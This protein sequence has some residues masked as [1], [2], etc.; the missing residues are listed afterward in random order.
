[1]AT[2]KIIDDS[3]REKLNAPDHESLDIDIFLA[4]EPAQEL[5]SMTADPTADA[6]PMTA[7]AVVDTLTS[8]A[9]ASQEGVVSMLAQNAMD[10]ALTDDSVTQPSAV[11]LKQYWATNSV[12]ARVSPSVLAQ[13]LERE[14]VIAI[15]QARYAPLEELMDE[16]ALAPVEDAPTPLAWSVTKINAPLLWARGIDGG[17]IVVAVVDTGVNYT[18]DDLKGRMWSS[19]PAFPRHGFDF[20]H[21]DDNPMDELGH[22]TACAGIVAGDGTSG[23]GTGVAPGAS[24]MAIR[25]GGAERTFWDGLEFAVRQG[26][27][28]ISMS[29]SW[30]F[31]S[32][33][34]YPGWRRICETL[35]AA[36][37]LHAN[38]IGN[39]GTDPVTYPIPFNIA[40]PGNCPPPR[41]HPDMPIQQGKS[42][43]V[44]VGA[45]DSSD[46][47]SSSSGRGPAEWNAGPYTDYPF[48]GGA[49]P[50]L[51]KPDVCAP[52][53]GTQSC[54]WRFRVDAIAKPYVSF[55]GTSAATPHVAGCMA[56]LAHATLRAGLRPDP[57]RI[58]EALESTAVRVSGQ[59]QA[60]E[61]HFG[62]GR[63]DVFEAFRFGEAKGWWK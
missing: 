28:V 18:H 31:P 21:H 58:L 47:L 1:M 54:N 52:G 2:G 33:P 53:P 15:H 17:G 29:M 26:A 19:N 51:I 11:I 36:G 9:L 49:Q 50:G 5:L 61:N 62:S 25:V 48:S 60:K 8:R 14:D 3:L 55:G 37:I 43:V 59:T 4:A 35:L 7:E 57:A 56:L 22:G 27:Q 13:L 63:I 45:T 12:A 10:A 32:H 24:I 30:K 42:S 23:L 38:S 41:F 16:A 20:A 40:A 44:S 39:Q 46:A 6:E 34:N